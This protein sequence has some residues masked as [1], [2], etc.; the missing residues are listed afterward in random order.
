MS[1]DTASRAGTGTAVIREIEDRLGAEVSLCYQCKRCTAGCPA[2]DF[3]DLRPHQ[4]V[5]LVRLGAAAR[6]IAGEAIWNCVGCYACTTRCPQNV[7][8]TELIYSLKNQ[9]LKQG[10]TPRGA[11]IPAFLKAFASTVQRYGRSQ[12]AHMLVQYYVTTD[13]GTAMKETSTAMKLLRQGR[14]PLL[15]H[16][17]RGWKAVKKVLRKAARGG[18]A[19]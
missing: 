9:A 10:K 17:V 4:L 5:R 15:P 16:R 2:A 18:G 7:P 13:P 6:A 3:M 8:I 11:R 14:L 19:T 1:V 12:E